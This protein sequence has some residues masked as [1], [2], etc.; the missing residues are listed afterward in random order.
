MQRYA[1]YI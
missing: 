1:L